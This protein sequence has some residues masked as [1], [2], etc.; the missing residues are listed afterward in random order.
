VRRTRC[1]LLRG[2]CAP[3]PTSARSGSTRKQKSRRPL[4]HATPKMPG[5]YE[6]RP[7]GGFGRTRPAC[8]LPSAVDEVSNHPGDEARAL[9]CRA[10]RERRG[11]CVG[12]GCEVPRCGAR[13][14]VVA[15]AWRGRCVVRPCAPPSLR[16]AS[17]G[18]ARGG[19]AS[20]IV[21][22]WPPSS[23]LLFVQWRLC[24]GGGATRR[25]LP[26]AHCHRARWFLHLHA[27]LNGTPAK[28]YLGFSRVRARRASISV[29]R[30]P[31]RLKYL[32]ITR[33]GSH[34]ASRQHLG[35]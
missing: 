12:R 4:N 23:H 19:P 6:R 16:R 21:D 25:R 30:L 27:W 24:G 10:R 5:P 17:Q 18:L 14:V 22:L 26:L 20:C 8:R 1:S 31:E 29:V 35:Q 28:P 32:R 13:A 11:S 15:A 3:T 2:L 33:E 34:G 7:G 9:T